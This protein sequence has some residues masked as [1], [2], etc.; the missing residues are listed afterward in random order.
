[1]ATAAIAAVGLTN[2]PF[3]LFNGV[4]TALNVGTTAGVAWAIGA[5]DRDSAKGIART[6]ILM[7]AVIGA[8][9]AVFLFKASRTASG[10]QMFFCH[11]SRAAPQLKTAVV[12]LTCNRCGN[13]RAENKTDG[14]G[15][16]Q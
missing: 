8:L 11:V 15:N 3:N 13:G 4:L 10:K 9:V 2:T 6:A 12:D 14:K 5:K 16:T 7:N 1:M